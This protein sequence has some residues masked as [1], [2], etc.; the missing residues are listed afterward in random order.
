M[1]ITIP[2]KHRAFSKADNRRR[3]QAWQQYRAELRRK[4]TMFFKLKQTDPERFESE[5][6][7][8]R[9]GLPLP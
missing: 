3:S 5:L 4:Q 2:K 6:K 7:A 8:R 1:I 9:D